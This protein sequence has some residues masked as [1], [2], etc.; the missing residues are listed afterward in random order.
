MKRK[1]QASVAV[2]TALRAVPRTKGTAL[3]NQRPATGR[4]LQ[5]FDALRSAVPFLEKARQLLLIV[6]DNLRGRLIHF[7][8]VAHLLNQVPLLS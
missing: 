7:H 5:L 4:R 2:A 6:S 8:P 1:R 3:D